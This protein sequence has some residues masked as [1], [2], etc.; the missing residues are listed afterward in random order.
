MSEKN[1]RLP[2]ILL[3]ENI[4]SLHNI[5][6][7]FRSSDGANIQEIVLSPLCATPPRGEISKT[8][9]G[10]ELTVPW[11][12]VS[13]LVSHAKLLKQEGYLICA[14]EQ[15]GRSA[16]FYKSKTDFP[17]ALVIGHEREGVSPEL[18]EICD[19]HLELP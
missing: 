17:L 6:S 7:L 10:A 11:K 8:A 4:R 12:Q 9:L 1:N 15:T 16:D 19:L 5:G 18:L 13:D 14:L 2:V 3:V